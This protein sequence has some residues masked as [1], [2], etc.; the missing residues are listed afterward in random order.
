MLGQFEIQTVE[1]AK[2]KRILLN[3][4]GESTCCPDNMKTVHMLVLSAK[5]FS[6]VQNNP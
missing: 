6:S 4:N 1:Q 3:T 5:I 2:S